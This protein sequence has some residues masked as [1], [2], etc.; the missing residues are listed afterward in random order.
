MGIGVIRWSIWAPQD[1][2]QGSRIGW[3]MRS[4][5]E[6]QISDPGSRDMG[7]RRWSCGGP[8]HPLDTPISPYHHI[9]IYGLIV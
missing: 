2:P 6:L 5:C 4:G 3:I 1:V 9:C 8:E 7:I